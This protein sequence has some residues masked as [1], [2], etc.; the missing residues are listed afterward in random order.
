M[1][2]CLNNIDAQFQVVDF[3]TEIMV[4]VS[5]VLGRV[6]GF[7]RS[8]T[9]FFTGLIYSWFNSSKTSRIVS[10]DPQFGVL[11][12]NL[13]SSENAVGYTVSGRYDRNNTTDGGTRS[14]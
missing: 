2:V 12:S 4:D 14:E 11:Q 10:F 6:F 7:I 9:K 8:R 1:L 13:N 3:I 5:I